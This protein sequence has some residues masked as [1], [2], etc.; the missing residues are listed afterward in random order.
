M[1]FA[2][3]P[4]I[5]ARLVAME[6]NYRDELAKTQTLVYQLMNDVLALRERLEVLE[7]KRGPGR[8]KKDD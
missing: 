6:Q 3:G 5:N 4:K 1:G 2:L 8:P 7:N